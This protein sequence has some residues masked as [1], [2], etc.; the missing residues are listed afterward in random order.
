MKNTHDEIFIQRKLRAAI[1]YGEISVRQNSVRRYFHTA[2]FLFGKIYFLQKCRTPKFPYAEISLRQNFLQQIFL[3]VK[4]PTA[5]FNTATV[6]KA[7][8]LVCRDKT[9]FRR[10]IQRIW[11]DDGLR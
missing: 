7:N 2:K 1:F 3:T 5:E 11:P 10:K 8:Y 6:S 9:H 4:F